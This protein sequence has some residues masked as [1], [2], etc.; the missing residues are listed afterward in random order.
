[1]SLLEERLN[2]GFVLWKL[3]QGEGRESMENGSKVQC[4]KSKVMDWSRIGKMRG[5]LDFSS[6]HGGTAGY[7]VVTFPAWKYG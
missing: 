2:L 1:M 4:P 7:S 3:K 6:R 5:R